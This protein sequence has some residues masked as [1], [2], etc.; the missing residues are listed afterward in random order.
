MATF[1]GFHDMGGSSDEDSIKSSWEKYKE[2]CSK[3]GLKAQHA[4][5]SADKGRAY[6]VTE[7]SSADEVQKAHDDAGVPINEILEIQTSE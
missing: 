4:H 6:C 1:M 3:M 7:A 5:Y 2:S